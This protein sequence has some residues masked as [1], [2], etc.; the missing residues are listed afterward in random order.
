MTS[1]DPRP[2]AAPD[3]ARVYRLPELLRAVRR[4]LEG[5]Y[6]EIWVEGEVAGFKLHTSGHRYFDL[7]D[8]GATLSCVMW[9]GT[10]QRTS[11]PLADGRRVRCRGTLTIWEGGGRFQMTVQ[12]VE[13]AGAGDIAARIEELKRKLQ[14]EGLTAPERKR[15][16]P[17]IPQK[18]G[19]V[20][21]LAGAALRDVL[22]VLARRVPVP[23]IVADCK[24][25]GEGAPASIVAALERVA[26]RPGIDAIIVTRGG[27][28]AQ[29][30]MAF[31][32]EAVARALA[33]CPVPVITAVGHEVDVTVADLV[34]D[35]RAAT[36]SEA[37]E[38]AVPTRADV[39]DRL[40]WSVTRGRRA[41]RDRLVAESRALERFEGRLPSPDG[42]LGPPRQD[43]DEALE[44]GRR[45]LDGTLEHRRRRLEDLRRR[46]AAA[47]PGARLAR[48]RGRVDTLRARLAAWKDTGLAACWAH[49][50]LTEGALRG[51]APGLFA[52]HRE[53]LAAASARL[54]ALSP[55][56]VLGR[57]YA[58]ARD[59]SGRVLTDAGTV[60]VGDRVGVTLARGSLACDVREVAPATPVRK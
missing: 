4:M 5:T 21:S 8:P 37:A 14:Q 3:P 60:A 18:L 50:D 12:L 16:L 17:R 32:D 35:L 15:P 38:R 49:L 48:D 19:V 6:H 28:S 39:A 7:R 46:L 20:T 26:R 41:L 10:A 45:A 2:P 9:R 25:Q 24:V 42:L 58:V 11:P 44:R 57:G 53:R 27:G 51:F 33:A 22:K 40:R 31:N 52:A 36:P 13:P 55:L 47:H 43:L 30:L 34:A 29:D 59:A 54:E 1:T 56:A 23:V